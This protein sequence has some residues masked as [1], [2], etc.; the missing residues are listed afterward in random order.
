MG[1][2]WNDEPEAAA[3]CDDYLELVAEDLADDNDHQS[4]LS[5]LPG[6][7]PR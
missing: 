2:N 5:P 3:G 7:N 1:L 4:L 6:R